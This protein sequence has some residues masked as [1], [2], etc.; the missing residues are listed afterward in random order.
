MKPVF[1][2]ADTPEILAAVE[3]LGRRTAVLAGFET[4]V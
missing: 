2:L 1:G 4:D 3:A